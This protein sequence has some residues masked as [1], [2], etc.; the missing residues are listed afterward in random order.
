[1]HKKILKVYLEFEYEINNIISIIKGT[2]K[3]SGWKSN[4]ATL[5]ITGYNKNTNKLV[6][7]SLLERLL[8]WAILDKGKTVELR[9]KPCRI[10]NNLTDGKIIES[11]PMG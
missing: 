2:A 5:Y 9:A 8:F 3:T 10:N 6:L 1:M 11:H 4:I 7:V